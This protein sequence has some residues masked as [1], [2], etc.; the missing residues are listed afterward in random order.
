[1]LRR[2]NSISFYSSALNTLHICCYYR[3]ERLGTSPSRTNRK[4]TSPIIHMA[5][6]NK[7][8]LQ[9]TVARWI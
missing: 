3:K 6:V 7:F 4:A 5:T 9:K 2:E 1:V 8:E